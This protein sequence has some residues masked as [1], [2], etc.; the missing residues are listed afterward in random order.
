MANRHSVAMR[1]D[2]EAILDGL[3]AQ[4]PRSRLD[5]YAE[6]IDEMRR[7]NWTYRGIAQILAEKCN[8]KVSP[9]NIHHFLKLRQAK[10][11]HEPASKRTQTLTPE[12]NARVSLQREPDGL[13]GGKRESHDVRDRI[14]ALKRRSAPPDKNPRSFEFDA[15][16][17]YG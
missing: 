1:K 12:T 14:D 17:P 11:S 7:R 5:P 13:A 4:P 16:E 2:L 8:V 9:S 3:P 6:L 15:A 10:A